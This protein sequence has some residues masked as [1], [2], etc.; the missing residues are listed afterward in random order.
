MKKTIVT[1]GEIMGRIEA[2]HNNTF[3]QALPGSV[4]ITYAGAEAN[5]AASLAMF[6]RETQFVTVLPDNPITRACVFYLRGLGIGIN[7]VKFTN[8]GR[9][10]LYFLE[11]GANQRPSNVVYDRDYS[12]ISI[13]PASLYDWDTIFKD[14]L[15]YHISGIT[16]ALSRDAAK[17]AIESV[18]K[19]KEYG[20]RVSCDLNY[21][22]K[23]WLWDNSCSKKE[24]AQKTMGELLPYVDVI[25]GNEEDASDVLAIHPENVD[26]NSGHLN[27]DKYVDVAKEIERKFPSVSYIAFTLRESISATYNR[28]GAMLYDVSTGKA[29]FSP[30]QNDEYMPY[31]IKSII[32]RVGGGDSFSAG[33]I[34]ALTGSEFNDPEKAVAFAASASCLCHSIHGDINYSMK[35][36]VIRLMQGNASGRVIR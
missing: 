29:Y 26:V 23:L 12:S 32:D 6:G 7:H 20:V 28:W 11:T 17:A 25:I 1:F 34:Y 10:G 22:K 24:L 19:A 9:F 2:E 5:V 35:E 16:P 27:I 8:Q 30:K 36:D 14:A 18:K 21:R 31:E 33:L 4:K 15:W 13:A 3:L